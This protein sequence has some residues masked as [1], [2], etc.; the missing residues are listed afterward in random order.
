MGTRSVPSNV[1]ISCP[2][3]TLIDSN[4]RYRRRLKRYVPAGTYQRHVDGRI[5]SFDGNSQCFEEVNTP[6]PGWTLI[7]RNPSTTDIAAGIAGLFQLHG[8]GQMWSFDGHSQ[9]PVDVTISCPGWTLIDRNPSTES[10]AVAGRDS[11][12]SNLDQ[13]HGDGEIWSFDG[14]SQCPVDVTIS[15]PGWTLIDRNP[16]TTDIVVAGGL[17]VQRHGDGQIW[18]YEAVGES[19]LGCPVDVTISCPGWVLI[20]RN[21]STEAIAGGDGGVYQRHGDGQI[22]SF[23][24]HSRCP[25]VVTI[26]CPGWTLIDRNPSTTDIV[27][28]GGFENEQGSSLFQLHGDGAVWSFDGHS[29]CPVDVT[30]SC[31][32]W[33]LIDR[34]PHTK[35]IIAVDK[36][37]V[38]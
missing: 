1:T 12:R 5:W 7:D 2:G 23:D 21:P 26:S 37:V 8:D 6:C 20:D 10:I 34:N 19:A 13:L 29:Q 30:I 25:D 35:A 32:G 33:T 31:P 17:L 11:S 24:G 27:A 14:H 36:L 16:S 18:R 28:G 9:C 15:C 22:W 4:P 38:R 3:W